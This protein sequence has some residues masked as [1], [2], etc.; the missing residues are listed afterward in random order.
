VDL[1]YQDNGS[2]TVPSAAVDPKTGEVR[3][4][5]SADG[6]YIAGWLSLAGVA[7]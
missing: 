4:K 3:L 7:Q 1:S 5:L 6:A 2:T